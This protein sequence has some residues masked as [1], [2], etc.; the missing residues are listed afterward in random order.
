MKKSFVT[1][2][3]LLGAVAAQAQINAITDTGD[4]VI[5]FENGS[6]IYKDSV[7]NGPSTNIPTSEEIYT[8]PKD[9]SFLVK[10]KRLNIGVYLNPKNW[11]FTKGE[12]GEDSEFNFQLRGGDLYAI[13]I[14]EKISI[15]IETLQKIAF[16]NAFSVSADIEITDEEFR[17]VND[18][19]LLK[20]DMKGT[21]Q[22]MKIAYSGYYF[23]NDNG[24]VQ[25]LAYTS[26]SLIEDYEKEISELLNGF[27]TLEN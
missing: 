2:L 12:E 3:V 11:I 27:V 8:K 5:L 16:D 20:M 17:V 13:L 14:T 6:W 18:N 10:S 21:I 24:S 26:Q 22:G 9:A 7:K 1:L 23:S 19:K 25:F 15:P 4:E